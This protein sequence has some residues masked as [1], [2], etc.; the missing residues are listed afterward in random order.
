MISFKTI[1]LYSLVLF[2]IFSIKADEQLSHF[3]RVENGP[4]TDII[5]GSISSEPKPGETSFQRSSQTFVPE[6]SP[7]QTSFERSQEETIPLPGQT[8]LDVSS[9]DSDDIPRPGE[10]RF[11]G[12]EINPDD[13]PQPDQTQFSDGSDLIRIRLGESSNNLRP[14]EPR[15]EAFTRQIQSS[16]SNYDPPPKPGQTEFRYYSD[17]RGSESISVGRYQDLM[18]HPSIIQRDLRYQS[19][20]D[21]D[22]LPRP[23]QPDFSVP[24]I[25]VDEDGNP[26]YNHRD[27][28]FRDLPQSTEDQNQPPQ[29]N[30]IELQPNFPSGD[31]EVRT[32]GLLGPNQPAA[33]YR[34]LPQS[35]RENSR[36]PEPGQIDF[37]DSSRMYWDCDMERD[38]MCH[39]E[40]R[41][42]FVPFVKDRFWNSSALVLDI[43]EAARIRNNLV[44]LNPVKS[45]NAGRLSTT[46]YL[47]AQN[48]QTACLH[49]SYA[50]SGEEDK[51]MHLLQRGRDDKCIYSAHWNPNETNEWNDLEL[52]LD[53]ARNGDS[54]F[55]IEFSFDMPRSDY[56][57][58]K[59]LGKIAIRNFQ[60]GYGR[61]R[62]NRAIDCDLPIRR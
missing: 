2:S 53:L 32:D 16:I 3:I 11:Q 30:R 23:N 27:P 40:N 5:S 24:T 54:T 25:T 50:W 52:E 12:P 55:L 21:S 22:N 1:L 31:F 18:N 59:R 10:S 36:I 57:D 4:S 14:I 51:R 49:F 60:I 15:N 33:R 17:G 26:I 7:G 34:D 8:E 38:D 35:Y 19:Q 45:Y 6:P 42:N 58:Y 62:N 13:V 39:L 43:G 56:Y 9:K 20:P 47:P 61:C 41:I 46:D 28:R 48:Q 44:Q 37:Y 29:P